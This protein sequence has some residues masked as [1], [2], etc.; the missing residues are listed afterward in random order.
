MIPQP[1][2]LQLEGP[3]GVLQIN[4]GEIRG[5]LAGDLVQAQGPG[6]EIERGVQ[7]PDV[8]VLMDH[9]E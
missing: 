4:D 6:I 1:G 3:G 5:G 9:L 8:E 7:I 2:E